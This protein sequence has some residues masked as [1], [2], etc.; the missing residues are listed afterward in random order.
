MLDTIADAIGVYRTLAAADGKSPKT[1]E[2]VV[3][4]SR[5]F[6]RFLGPLTPLDRVTK[7]DVRRFILNRILPS[8]HGTLSGVFSGLS[9]VQRQIGLNGR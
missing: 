6:E 9:T 7:H 4:G 2:R 3:N 1:I 5:L 8:T